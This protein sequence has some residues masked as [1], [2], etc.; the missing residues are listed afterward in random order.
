VY[1]FNQQYVSDDH[2]IHG[3]GINTYI[4]TQTFDKLSGWWKFRFQ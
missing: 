2:Y 3:D 1:L 4:Q